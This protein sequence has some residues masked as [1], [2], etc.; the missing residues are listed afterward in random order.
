VGEGQDHYPSNVRVY[1]QENAWA[2]TTVMDQITDDF[3]TDV[4]DIEGGAI[5]VLTTTVTSRSNWLL[6]TCSPVFTP[7]QCTDPVYHHVNG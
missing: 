7:S 1:W 6:L 2:D 4:A 3:L 5:L